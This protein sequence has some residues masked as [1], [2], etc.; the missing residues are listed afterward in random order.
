MDVTHQGEPRISVFSCPFLFMFLSF[1]ICCWFLRQVNQFNLTSDYSNMVSEWD[2][3]IQYL[4]QLSI[5]ND[6]HLGI[7][8][9]L[10]IC[11]LSGSHQASPQI[12][13]YF[14][15]FLNP[16]LNLLCKIFAEFFQGFLDVFFVDLH[17]FGALLKEI[18]LPIIKMTVIKRGRNLVSFYRN[19]FYNLFLELEA[20]LWIHPRNQNKK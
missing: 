6:Y 12:W 14:C 5:N 2:A 18:F 15:I 8:I 11:F 16:N 19:F 3:M 10:Q 1:M 13:T 7:V 4:L 9:L 20:P 17:D